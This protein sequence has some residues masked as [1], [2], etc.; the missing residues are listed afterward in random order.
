MTR[1]LC[2]ILAAAIV[3]CSSPTSEKKSESKSNSMS[4]TQGSPPGAG[5]PT[6]NESPETNLAQNDPKRTVKTTQEAREELQARIDRYLGG[7][8]VDDLFDGV[9]A[10]WIVG[11]K[12][13][14]MQLMRVVQKYDKE[15][16]I[17]QNQFVAAI[18]CVGDSSL[19]LK[20]ETRE[21]AIPDFAFRNGAWQFPFLR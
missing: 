2:F 10:I 3:G 17:V 5:Q 1:C 14:S 20:R 7:Q 8:S 12:V 19:S 11:V 21:F 15:G 13:E 6:K 16:K 18:K 4:D 9:L